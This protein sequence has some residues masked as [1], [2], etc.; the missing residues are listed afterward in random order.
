MELSEIADSVASLDEAKQ[1]I[2]EL[3]AINQGL[4]TEVTTL[5]TMV[6]SLQS[7]QGT[8]SRNSS[9]APSTDSPEQRAKE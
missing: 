8:S 5:K 9:K 4:Q 7:R 6:E 3:V 2:R 1:L